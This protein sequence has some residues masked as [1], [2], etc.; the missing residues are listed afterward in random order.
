MLA[1]LTASAN[2]AAILTGYSDRH[3][4]QL[5]STGVLPAEGNRHRRIPLAEIAA[6]RGR[7]I[8]DQEYVEALQMAEQRRAYW[9]EYRRTRA[10][11]DG[12]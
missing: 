4:R 11:S 7:E 3:I 10:G 2:L 9:R 8:T 1:T 6:L 5:V 12:P